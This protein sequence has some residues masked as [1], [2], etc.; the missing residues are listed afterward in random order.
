MVRGNAGPPRFLRGHAGPPR[1][2][3]HGYIA[4]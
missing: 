2:V 3:R 1:G 4:A